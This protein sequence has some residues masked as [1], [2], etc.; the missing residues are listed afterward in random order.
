MDSI[1]SAPD[2]LRIWWNV[3]AVLVVLMQVG[4][5]YLEMGLV[6]KENRPGIAFKNLAI[7]LVSSLAYSTIGIKI[8][9]GYDVFSPSSGSTPSYGW[10]FYQTGFAAVAATIISGALAGRTTVRAN[11]IVGAVMAGLVYPLFGRLVWNTEVHLLGDIHDF[12]GSGVVHFVGGT[13]ACVGAIVAGPRFQTFEQRKSGKKPPLREYVGHRDLPW[14]T[15]AVVMLWV[16]WLGFNSG[17]FLPDAIAKHGYALIG[18]AALVTSQAA[19]AGGLTAIA[20][21]WHQLRREV[22]NLERRMEGATIHAKTHRLFDPYAALTGTM[23]GMVAITANCDWILVLGKPW[24]ALPIG[25]AGGL[26]ALVFAQVVRRFGV[27]DPVEAIGVHAGAGAVGV[28]LASLAPEASPL[29]QAS[30]LL[31]AL[32]ITV[33]LMLPVF[34]VLRHPRFVRAFFRAVFKLKVFRGAW[35]FKK[36]WKDLI[37]SWDAGGHLRTPHGEEVI[38]LRPMMPASLRARRTEPVMKEKEKD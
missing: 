28:L 16:G 34:V 1:D 31:A 14:A 20:M 19:S 15:I 22:R 32:V 35:D 21:R 38:G 18:G 2:L 12:A 6:R 3:S 24:M 37:D 11:V 33:G 10:I 8:M 17:S 26:A 9:Y 36:D 5:I 23:G 13:A 30:S 27:D 25:A 29:R 4:F 7:F